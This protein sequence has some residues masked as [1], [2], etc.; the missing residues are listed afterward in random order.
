M[1]M[2][3]NFKRISSLFFFAVTGCSAIFAQQSSLSPNA[4][5]DDL[6]QYAMR[7]K[8]ELQQAQIDREIGEREI[9]SALSGW[10][11]QIQTLMDKTSPWDSA[12]TVV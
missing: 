12:T 2:N 10:F 7:N 9:A 5:L 6:I 8:I 4:N 1:N 11:P 3:F